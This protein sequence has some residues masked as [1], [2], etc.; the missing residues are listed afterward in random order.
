M[1][2]IYMHWHINHLL[3]PKEDEWTA[4]I[5][6]SLISDQKSATINSFRL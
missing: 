6:K 4:R 5:E 1:R 3:K 2:Q